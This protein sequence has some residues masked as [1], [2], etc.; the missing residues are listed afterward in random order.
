MKDV[1]TP[2]IV[3]K[4][5]KMPSDVGELEYF[6]LIVAE[7]YSPGKFYWFLR[8]NRAVIESL[9]DDMKYDDLKLTH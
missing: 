3:L 5:Q 7:V 1:Y 9:T 8:Q 4:Y 6:F 2:D